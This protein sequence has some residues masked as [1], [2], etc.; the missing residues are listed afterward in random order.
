MV[1]QKQD[2]CINR[3]NARHFEKLGYII[4]RDKDKRGRDTIM[5]QL[6]NVDIDDIPKC[7]KIKI[8]IRKHKSSE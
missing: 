7:S 4:K 6:L 1:E 5:P 2:I 8:E 3:Y